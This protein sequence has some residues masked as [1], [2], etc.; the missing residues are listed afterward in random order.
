MSVAN[1]P[2]HNGRES[3]RAAM[4]VANNHAAMAVKNPVRD[5]ILVGGFWQ[6]NGNYCFIA[7]FFWVFYCVFQKNAL[8]LSP[9]AKPL[10]FYIDKQMQYNVSIY[11]SAIPS[12]DPSGTMPFHAREIPGALS[13]AED[14][15]KSFWYPQLDRQKPCSPDRLESLVIRMV[16]FYRPVKSSLSYN[17]NRNLTPVFTTANLRLSESDAFRRQPEVHK[18]HC[19]TS[20]SK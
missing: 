4:S 3:H 2:N 17:K 10:A 9:H 7:V 20:V 18:K 6:K 13:P 12:G 1:N 19:V 8:H 15:I 11:N 5:G 16:Y 14:F